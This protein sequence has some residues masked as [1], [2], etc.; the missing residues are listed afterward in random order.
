MD[1]S[2][3][4]LTNKETFWIGQIGNACREKLADITVLLDSC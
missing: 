2:V 3:K 1:Y 4:I